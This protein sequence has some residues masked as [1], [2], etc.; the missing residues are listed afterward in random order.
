MTLGESKSELIKKTE[1]AGLI[2]LKNKTPK[3]KKQENLAH[4]LINKAGNRINS[5]KKAPRPNCCWLSSNITVHSE[6]SQTFLGF[7][8]SSHFMLHAKMFSHQSTLHI[9]YRQSKKKTTTDL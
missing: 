4:C 5:N 3:K 9:P 1:N 7:F 2:R 8:S 6:S